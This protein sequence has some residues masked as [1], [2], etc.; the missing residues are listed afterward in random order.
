[1]GLAILLFY[2]YW[3]ID[4][5]IGHLGTLKV[6]SYGNKLMLQSL[7]KDQFTNK[8]WTKQSYSGLH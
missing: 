6:H 1:M 7:T 5:D 2:L 4:I 8:L 3:F